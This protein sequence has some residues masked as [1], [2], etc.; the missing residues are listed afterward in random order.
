MMEQVRYPVREGTDVAV[1]ESVEWV[2]AVGESIPAFSALLV[3][4]FYSYQSVLSDCVLTLSAGSVPP[5]AVAAG[6]AI[7]A[8]CSFA[9]VHSTGAT[10]ALAV[11]VVAASKK[12]NR[13]KLNDM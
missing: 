1:T 12:E 6:V 11:F 2:V 10:T 9:A 4:C 13:N 5:A 3:C 8:R 7:A